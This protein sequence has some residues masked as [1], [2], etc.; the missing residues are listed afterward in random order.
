MKKIILAC[1]AVAMG[2][3]MISCSGSSTGEPKNYEDS[4]S[5]YMGKTQGAYFAKN[6]DQIPEPDKSKFDKESFLRGLK[7][8]L[9]ADT[10]EVGYLYG[11]SVG[12]NMMNQLTMMSRSDVNVN[13]DMVYNQFAAAFKLDS[14]SETEMEELNT[15]LNALM[16]QA[17]QKMMAKQQEQQQAAMKELQEKADK[18]KADGAAFV[19][20]A[21]A[22]D[23][24]IKTTESGLSYKVEKEGTGAKAVD[25]DKVKVI[26]TGKLID[27][28]VFDTSDGQP[29]EFSPNQVIPGFAEGLKMMNKGAKYTLYIPGE[30]AY[31]MQGTPDGKIPPMSTLVFEVEVVDITK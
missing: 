17:H 7:T 28:T 10:A 22:D 2:L 26:Y 24:T 30:I 29:V 25:G 21:K 6:V 14:V 31:G 27:G 13:R 1:T 5:Y 11:V 8:I 20:K 15:T 9:E 16:N 19:E 12:L 4:L 3:G 18:N 23:N